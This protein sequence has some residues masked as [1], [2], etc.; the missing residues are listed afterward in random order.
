MEVEKVNIAAKLDSF[1]E[2]W[3]PKIVGA[4]NKQLVKVA[5][6]KGDFIMHHHEN[7]DELFY[8]IDGQLF[9]E[10]EDKTLSLNRG[11]FVIIPRG[12]K[13]KPYAP[14][15]VSVLLFEPATTLNTGNLSNSLTQE[16]LDSI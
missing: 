12:V 14:E 5:K 9:I 6:F 1:S 16:K 15:E 11:E 4:L 13:H 3:S 7:E 10:L 2:H 8:V